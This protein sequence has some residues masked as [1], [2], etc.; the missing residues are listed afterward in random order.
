MC[1]SAPDGSPLRPPFCY[2]DE[3]TVAAKKAADE[4]APPEELFARTGAQPHRIN[5]IYQLLADQAAGV[6]PAAPW[7]MMPEYCFT[8]SADG[9]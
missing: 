7:V 1:A 4:I 3:R 2:R 6:D 5:T 9:A 8:A